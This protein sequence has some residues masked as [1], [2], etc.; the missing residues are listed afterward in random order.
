M[1]ALTRRDL[2]TAAE[3]Q[4]SVISMIPPQD[5]LKRLHADLCAGLADP[6]RIA[7]LYVLHEREAN[8]TDLTEQ[9]SL[10]QS[11]VSRHLAVLRATNLVYAKRQGQNTF[12]Q[13]TDTRV[14]DALD[15]L[16]AVLQAR[17]TRHAEAMN[18]AN[19]GS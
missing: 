10:P 2:Q 6:T 8:V 7:I 13:L 11:T 12:Y 16:R 3:I 4:E 19:Q 15:L 17:V 5:E 9:L 1:E 14:I 18:T